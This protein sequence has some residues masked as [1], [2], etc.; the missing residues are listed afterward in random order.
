MRLPRLVFAAALVVLASD[1]RQIQAETTTAGVVSRVELEEAMRSHGDY[2]L[3]ATTNGPRFQIDVFSW[4][5]RRSLASQP[6]G[7]RLFIRHADWYEVFLAV[8]QLRPQEAAIVSRLV[9]EN[10][11]DIELDCRPPRV[12]TRVRQGPPV[13][14]AFNVKFWWELSANPADH[15]TYLDEAATPVLKV[16]N[17]RVI[18][19]RIVDLGEQVLFDEIRGLTGRPT[20]GFLGLLFKVIGDGHIVRSQMAWAADGIQVS[21][22]VAQKLFTRTVT[23]VT[24]PDGRTEAEI[25]AGRADLTALEERLDRPIEIDYYTLAQ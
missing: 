15:F 22:V 25:P 5:V 4:L 12:V 10:G 19:Y 6:Q 2:N 16:T 17:S 11:Q 9:Y 1:V 24:Y 18:T 7:G 20:T 23:V 14:L 13:R 21:R 3:A 8:A